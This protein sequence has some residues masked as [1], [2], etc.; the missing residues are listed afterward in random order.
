[1]LVV[2]V[3][4]DSAMQ[5]Q[6]DYICTYICIYIYTHIHKGKAFVSY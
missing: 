3:Q 6:A 1:M 2:G 4:L 5:K